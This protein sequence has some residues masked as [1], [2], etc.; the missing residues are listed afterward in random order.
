[1]PESRLTNKTVN[2]IGIDNNL[3]SITMEKDGMWFYI[4]Y[5]CFTFRNKIHMLL[6][7]YFL[8]TVF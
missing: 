6:I 3:M 8:M 7:F 1:M 5:T 4:S 2:K